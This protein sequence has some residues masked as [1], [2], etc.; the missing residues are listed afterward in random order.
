[1][2][3]DGTGGAG[4]VRAGRIAGFDTNGEAAGTA[5]ATGHSG[6]KKDSA[7]KDAS[8][9]A[10]Y[11][12]D[13]EL[14][15]IFTR[16]FGEIKR[17]VPVGANALGAQGTASNKDAMAQARKKE[18]AALERAGERSVE[19]VKKELSEN[20]LP[21]YLLVDGYNVIFAWEELSGLARENLESAR[22]RLMDILCNYQGYTKYRII[23]VFD[24]YRVKGNPGE[25]V[26]YHNIHVVYTKEAET[27]D[28]YIEKV[29][30]ELGRKYH[31]TVATSD[32]LEQLIVIGQGAVRMSSRELKE[33]VE[34]VSSRYLAEHAVH[35]GKGKNSQIQEALKKALEKNDAPSG[36]KDTA[37][38]PAK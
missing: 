9:G 3:W 19:V 8:L 29:S 32:A 15:E 21:E 5:D 6:N 12:A 23:L 27:A 28:M 30:H 20:R 38:N 33:E 18:Q 7:K 13:K 36:A 25:V 10:A 35:G 17:R 1:E 31:V 22:G 34:R 11:A 2:A 14:E 24:A 26:K 4:G 37:K 16:T